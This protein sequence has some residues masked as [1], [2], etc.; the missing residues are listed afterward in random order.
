MSVNNQV[1]HVTC[2][3]W[4]TEGTNL[5]VGLTCGF[6]I[7]STELL[8]DD[9]GCLCEVARRSVVG[10]VGHIALHGQSNVLLFVGWED[11]YRS[12]VTL[13]DLA[14]VE[15][16]N[17]SGQ[18]L[19]ASLVLPSMVNA[20][21]FHPR[22]VIIGVMSGFVYFFDHTLRLIESFQ[23]SKGSSKHSSSSSS[24]TVNKIHFE[25][26]TIAFGSTLTEQSASGVNF[27]LLYGVILGPTTG[28]VRCI[29]YSSERRKVSHLLNESLL[30]SD[31]TNSQ[32]FRVKILNLHRNE[33]QC[34]SVT[35]NGT[36]ALSVSERGTALKFFDVE[37]GIPLYQFF[38]GTTPNKVHTLSLFA[39]STEVVAI[40]VSDTGTVHLFHVVN[41]HNSDRLLI[42]E[43]NSYEQVNDN[44]LFS[45]W[46]NY[47]NSLNSKARL[48]IPN[49]ELY[50]ILCRQG[51]YSKS[52]YSIIIHPIAKENSYLAQIV[53]AD[54]SSGKEAVK[55][56]LLL[57]KVDLASTNCM[58]IT[59]CSYFPKD[60]L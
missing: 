35:I 34:I 49:D 21:R 59:R 6:I 28:S 25:S 9:D 45:V 27:F 13:Y 5:A 19:L 18:Q 30:D 51:V 60:E 33:V 29:R 57:L 15:T 10:G 43:N 52:T 55:A 23:V 22:L 39:S 38:R 4:N 50:D 8:G 31:G 20:V 46:N 40:C 26:S 54:F 17:D 24:K 53:Q 12:T 7:Y 41:S 58:E 14:A 32:P 11:K 56:R 37:R 47:R 16:S 3:S 42:N 48:T 44:K 1:R 2:F 36:H